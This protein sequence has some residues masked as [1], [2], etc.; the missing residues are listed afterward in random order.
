MKRNIISSFIAVVLLVCFTQNLKAQRQNRAPEARFGI[1][2][3]YNMSDLTSANGLDAFNGV[4]FYN[5]QK[6]Y[7]GFTDTKPFQTGFNVGFTGQIHIAS[8][9]YF[10]PSLI[11]T[12]KGYKVNTQN[13]DNQYQNIEITA[14]AYYAQLPLDVVW[15]YSV[16]DD[17]R[18]FVSGGGFVGIGVG[19]TTKFYDHYGEFSQTGQGH[20]PGPATGAEA[21]DAINGYIGYD[22]TVHG[23][24]TAYNKD[25]DETFESDGTNKIDAGLELGLGFEWKNFQLTLG[26]QYSLTPLYNYDYDYTSRYVQKYHTTKFS[27]SFDYLGVQ[28]PTSP[29]QYLL[30]VTLSYYLDIFTNR[31]KW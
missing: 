30:S 3:G 18:F 13:K 26:F 28:K 7:V 29:C 1:R 19:G 16:N 12:T 27:N 25:E 17:W 20:V 22:C 5:Q 8:S 24:G 9:W 14:Q 21:P 6:Q 10:Q 2:V 31:F 15:K 23:L 11:F 4:A